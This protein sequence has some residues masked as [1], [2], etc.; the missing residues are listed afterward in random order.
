MVDWTSTPQVLQ[1]IFWGLM[2]F[3]FV[4][5]FRQGDRLV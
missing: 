1:A 4:A 2:F 3:A 5:G